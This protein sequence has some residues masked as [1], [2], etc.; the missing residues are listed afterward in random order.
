MAEIGIVGER[1]AGQTALHERPGVAGRQRAAGQ[2]DGAGLV[3]LLDGPD[4][5]V[6]V[7]V[8]GAVGIGVARL[9][10]RVLGHVADR[11]QQADEPVFRFALVFV[12]ERKPVRRAGI[13]MRPAE[14]QPVVGPA[15]RFPDGDR[16]IDAEPPDPGDLPGQPLVAVAVEAL[17][18]ILERLRQL[19]LDRRVDDLDPDVRAP[20]FDRI[21]AQPVAFALVLAGLQVELPVVPVAGQQAVAV[22]RALAQRIALVRAAVV[23]GADALRG[24]EE[25]DLAAVEAEDRA[26]LPAQFVDA[27]SLDP[28]LFHRCASPVARRAVGLNLGRSANSDRPVHNPR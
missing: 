11:L 14:L 24:I 23:A 25:R 8:L 6:L 20:D 16:R 1:G 17:F 7:P 12:V 9:A 13:G 26:A 19:L 28:A 27:G 3:F 4:E 15:D 22:Q 10:Q 18:Q 21:D 5:G 2:A